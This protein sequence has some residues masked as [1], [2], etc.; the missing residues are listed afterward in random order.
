MLLKYFWGMLCASGAMASQVSVPSSC[1]VTGFQLLCATFYIKTIDRCIA[2]SLP[3]DIFVKEKEICYT[4]HPDRCISA[5]F[6]PQA[7]VHL[8]LT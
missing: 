6:C 3:T 1:T 7:Q 4:V 2:N 5:D 8:K